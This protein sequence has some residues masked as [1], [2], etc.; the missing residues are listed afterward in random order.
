MVPV[1][2]LFLSFQSIWLLSLCFPWLSPLSKYCLD[3]SSRLQLLSA[4]C[5]LYHAHYNY[6]WVWVCHLLPAHVPISL[7]VGRKLHPAA[8]ACMQQYDP[9]IDY[10]HYNEWD[11]CIQKSIKRSK[12]PKE[13]TC[14]QQQIVKRPILTKLFN[15]HNLHKID[16]VFKKLQLVAVGRHYKRAAMRLTDG[17]SSSFHLI[18]T[19]FA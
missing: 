4:V 10:L 2:F 13:T 7:R 6:L 12:L 1:C 17:Y 3:S 14:V 19:G 18:T 15:T 11:L 9:E 5:V 16:L 8:T